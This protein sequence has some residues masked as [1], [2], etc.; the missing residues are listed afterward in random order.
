MLPLSLE[1]ELLKP[2]NRKKLIGLLLGVLGGIAL[3]LLPR[4]T[5]G[6]V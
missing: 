4:C 1:A 3:G 2:I 5:T 6:G